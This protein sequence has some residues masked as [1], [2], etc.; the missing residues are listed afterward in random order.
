MP[1]L[2]LAVALVAVWVH[3]PC[4]RNSFTYWDDDLYLREVELHP[5]VTG[6]TLKWAFGTTQP[7]Y[8]HPPAGTGY[9]AQLRGHHALG[10]RCRL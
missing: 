4:V 10:A 9:R 1:V 2:A 7:F 8:Y 3:W 6:A 5:R